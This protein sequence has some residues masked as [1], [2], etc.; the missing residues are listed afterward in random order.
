MEN[1]VRTSTLYVVENAKEVKINKEAV[2]KIAKEWAKE[3][4]PES[5]WPKEMHLETDDEQALLTYL[6]ILDSVNFCFWSERERWRI[7]YNGKKYDGYFALSLALKKFFEENPQK[8]TFEYLAEISYEEYLEILQGGENLLFLKERWEN[9]QDVSQAMVREHNGDVRTFVS[10]AEKKCELLVKKIAELPSFDDDAIYNGQKVYFWKRA[11][12]LA[13]DIWGAFDG[14]GMGELQDRNW[15]TVFADYK[16][17][18][19]LS[20]VG[21]LEYSDRLKKKIEDKEKLQQ[22]EK[23][24]VEIRAATIWAAENLKNEMSSEYLKDKMGSKGKGLPAFELDWFLWN[25]AQ[26]IQ[27]P[28]H[29]TRTIHY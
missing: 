11:Q 4:I 2:K 18:Q 3:E 12:I 1:P 22:G 21:I 8:G 26:G 28:Y 29:F 27:A 19:I 7:T 25:K 24:E 6:I 23:E 14:K 9:I 16:I 17:P 5:Q 10:E 13:A 15:L 20:H